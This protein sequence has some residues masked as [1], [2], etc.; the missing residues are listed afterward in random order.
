M[1]PQCV[2]LR[3][4][5]RQEY[6]VCFC[7]HSK[8]SQRAEIARP[9][10][11]E[12]ITALPHPRTDMLPQTNKTSGKKGITRSQPRQRTVY[13]ALQWSSTVNVD[14]IS[15]LSR[16]SSTIKTILIYST[17]RPFS[18]VVASVVY[19]TAGLHVRRTNDIP[20][21]TDTLVAQHWPS[22]STAFHFHSL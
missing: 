21:N 2:Q 13:D 15:G 7:N 16:C 20:D 10:H 12:S 14:S 22:S 8:T 18:E 1:L 11:S 19:Q 9:A 17:S 3:P 5:R 4:Q 6:A